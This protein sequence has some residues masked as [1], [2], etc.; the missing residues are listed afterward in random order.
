M[1]MLKGKISHLDLNEFKQN[2]KGNLPN[3]PFG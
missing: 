1:K 2:K 3:G